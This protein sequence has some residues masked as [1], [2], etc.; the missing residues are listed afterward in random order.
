VIAYYNRAI[1]YN[2]KG[3]RDRAMAD[4]NE[5]I[6]LD[7]GNANASNRGAIRNAKGDRDGAIADFNEG[8][9][10]DPNNA[11]AFNNRRIA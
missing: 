2:M 9:R 10:L 6:R 5:A 1:V 11:T 4:Y 3:D 8:G 7:P